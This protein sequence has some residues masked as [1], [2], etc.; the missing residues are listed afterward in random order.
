MLKEVIKD[1]EIEV[2]ERN[3][4]LSLSLGQNVPMIKGQKRYLEEAF[5]NLINNAIKYTPSSKK[6]SDIRG[7][8]VSKSRAKII[9]SVLKDLNNPKN[10][11][12]K[13][14]DNGIGI[15]DAEKQ[16]L[17]NRF[18][19]AQNACEMYTDGTGLGLFIVKEIV[20]G[21]GGSI[22]Y[23]SEINKGTTFFV[24]L[25]IRPENNIN[26]SSYIAKNAESDPTIKL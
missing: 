15:P 17:F 23:E 26:I 21:H 25:P 8:R 10:I 19:R 16:K 6:T 3:I 24:S 20:E 13:I 14:K 4:D 2:K 1:F 5:I 18:S 22:W 12:V 7:E 9:V 11:L